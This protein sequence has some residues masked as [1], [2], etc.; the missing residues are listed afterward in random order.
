MLRDFTGISGYI[1]DIECYSI[2]LILPAPFP[3]VALY[4]LVSPASPDRAPQGSDVTHYRTLHLFERR[5]EMRCVSS[6]ATAGDVYILFMMRHISGGGF[7][8]R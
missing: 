6:S 4:R 7:P 2:M 5:A 8:G 1:C 3:F